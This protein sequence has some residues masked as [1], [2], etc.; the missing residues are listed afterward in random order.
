M[1]KIILSSF[2]I[3]MMALSFS[4]NALAECEGGHCSMKKKWGGECGKGKGQCPITEKIMKKAYFFLDNQK[5]LGLKE[6]Q[7]TAIKAIKMDVK[8]AEIRQMAEMQVFQIDLKTKLS[9]PTVDIE[10]IN[11][12]IDSMSAGMASSAKASVASYAKL[13]A[14]LSNEQMS[15]AKEIWGQQETGKHA[16]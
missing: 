11:A 13:K 2:L 7:V 10:G 15:K 16:G 9:E 4:G 3:A 1:K 5:A 12:M 6:D 14:V 8:K